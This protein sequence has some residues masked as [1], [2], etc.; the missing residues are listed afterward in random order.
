MAYKKGTMKKLQELRK[1]RGL[2][3]TQQVDFQAMGSYDVALMFETVEKWE[4][5]EPSV[6]PP[7]K[8][9]ALMFI[10]EYIMA[11][12][13]G[14]EPLP[15]IDIDFVEDARNTINKEKMIILDWIQSRYIIGMGRIS[16]KR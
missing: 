3:R 14:Y 2:L 16:L 12:L 4:K 15:P 10:H 13:A 8:G 5:V 9:S 1:I 6:M 7:I 11:T